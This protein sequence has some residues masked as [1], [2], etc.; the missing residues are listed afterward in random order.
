MWKNNV[1]NFQKAKVWSQGVPQHLLVQ[2]GTAY[3]SVTYKKNVQLVMKLF[4]QADLS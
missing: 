1:N 4:L 3:K 2:P